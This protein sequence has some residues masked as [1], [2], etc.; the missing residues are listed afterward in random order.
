[1]IQ[2]ARQPAPCEP[3]ARASCTTLP[4]GKERCFGDAGRCA[5][6]RAYVSRNKLETTACVDR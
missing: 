4:G 3:Q 6:Y 1:M 2:G 5:H